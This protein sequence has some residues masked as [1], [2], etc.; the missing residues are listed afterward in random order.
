MINISRKKNNTD[1]R[2]AALLIVLSVV[3]V[4]TIL[5]LGFL[6]RSDVE[7]ACGYNMALRAQMDCLAES[8]LQHAKGLILNPQDVDS[9]Y[10]MGDTAQ[11]LAAG[12][13]DYYSVAVVRDGS[14][15][16]NYLIDC[17]AYQLRDG[18]EV[19]RS[20]LI[21]E[22]RLDPCIA[23]WTGSGTTLWSGCAIKGDVYCGG[24]LTNKGVVD[25]DVFANAL[26][27]SITGQHKAIADL[28]LAW[29][30][31][32][33]SDFTSRYTTETVASGSLSSVTLGSCDPVRVCHCTG[34]LALAGDVH[35]EGMLVVDGNL[36]IGGNGNVLTSAKRLPALLV[37]G[38][39]IVESGGQLEIHG[40]AVIDGNVLIGGSSSDVIVLGGLFVQGILAEAAGD[41]SGNGHAA[42]LYNGPTWRP[43]GGM[44]DGAL[45][46]DGVDD[47]VEDLYAGSYLNGLSAITVSLWVKSDV[48]NGDYDIMFGSEPT[49]AD[50]ELGI[51]YDESGWCGGAMNCI[52]ASIR[53]TSDYTQIESSAYAQTTAWQHLVMVWQTGSSLKLYIN[54]GLDTLTFDLGPL[55]G[56]VSGVQ[57]LTLG[58]GTMGTHWDGLI[59]D[60]RIYG[61]ALDANDVYPPVNGLP[62]LV[63]HWRLDEDG[64]STIG[65]TAAPA[66]AAVVLWSEVGNEEQWGQA[67]GAFFRSIQRK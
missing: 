54:G 18:E 29:P 20:S 58:R 1:R 34:N 37:T 67:A 53:T 4:I 41:S 43:S 32:T 59:D 45:E 64:S 30:R 11:Q 47:S 25:G 38:D 51:R 2:G 61:C 16:C 12:S 46:F 8:G 49:G 33:V 21:A 31:V 24:A 23:L 52:K 3:M 5:A 35:I 60:V 44:T 22:L 10:W 65:V 55:A 57:K 40:L 15:R 42:V 9:E 56:T 26:S 36:T 28:P 63:A 6:S 27:G 48:I 13:Q 62:G 50:D 66:K 19:G 17:N 7:L 14:D 39:L